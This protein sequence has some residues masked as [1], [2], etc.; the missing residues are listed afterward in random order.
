VDFKFGFHPF[1]TNLG[2]G[3]KAGLKKSGL[4]GA[5]VNLGMTEPQQFMASALYQLTPALGLMGNVGWQNWSQ[6]GQTT[7]G[8]CTR[9]IHPGPPC[10][11]CM[12]SYDPSWRLICCPPQVNTSP[13]SAPIGRVQAFCFSAVQS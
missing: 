11:C 8:I 3:I 9:I 12:K 10:G 7:L 2:P 1:T 13:T 5:K 6:F 4:L